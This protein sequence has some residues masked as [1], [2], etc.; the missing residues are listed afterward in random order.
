MIST[1][2]ET[3]HGQEN[4][5]SPR[6]NGI[7]FLSSG[8]ELGGNIEQYFA[9]EGVDPLSHAFDG[10]IA[11]HP[12]VGGERVPTEEWENS[13]KALLETPRKG[14]SVAYIHVPFCETHCLYCGFYQRAYS[15]EESARYTD[16]LIRELQLW[17][18]RAAQEEGPIHAVYL[19]GGTPTALEAV[20]LERLLKAV[21]THLPLANDCEVTVEGR[22]HNFGP[23]K[24]EACFSGGAN[25]FSLGV[26]SFNT[27]IRQCMGRFASREELFRRLE[28]LK[29][30]NQAAVI[31]DL[32]F[33]FPM[34]SLDLWLEDIAAACSVE[35]DGLD[36][37]QLNVYGQTPLGK[38][39][40]EGKLPPAADIPLQS[41]MFAAGVEA[42]QKAFYRRLSL[43]HWARTSRERNL[44]NLKVKGRANCLAF[45]PGAGG[46]LAGWF[47]MNQNQ[48][49]KWE[50][51]VRA[52]RKPLMMLV[53][54][55]AHFAFFRA[56][57]EGMEQGWLDMAYLESCY[58]VAIRAVLRPLLAQWS[59][60]GLVELRGDTVLLTL[61]GQFW[62]VNLSQLMQD[63][64][65]H[66]LDTTTPG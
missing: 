11:V 35:L 65:K 2:K 48:Y 30:Y 15:R 46:N 12:G 66:A 22:L 63:Y 32:I 54:P 61:A 19:G 49:Q 38:A 60:A 39:I 59:R 40:I 51:A 28:L 57:A 29:S 45:G 25:R 1:L 36:C 34:Q 58:G 64:I 21:R 42:L 13:L 3:R 55:N 43:T 50:D 9:R 37:Y 47:F 5:L 4:F 18:G 20:D 53:R 52:G 56:V 7:A 6:I 33:G 17:G 44:Y 27:R 23:D 10:K 8:R 16:T 41:A 31:V 24:M 26:Q 14:D 62:Q